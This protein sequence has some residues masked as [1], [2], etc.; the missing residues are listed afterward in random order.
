MNLNFAPG[1]LVLSSQAHPSW[2]EKWGEKHV[3]ISGRVFFED[4]LS[5]K[6]VTKTSLQ[7]I[8]NAG[9]TALALADFLARR[10]LLLGMDMSGR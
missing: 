8:N 5:E 1:T 7:A 2:K 9:L 3:Y 10:I 6:G 4:W